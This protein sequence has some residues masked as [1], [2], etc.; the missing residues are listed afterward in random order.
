MPLYGY[1]MGTCSPLVRALVIFNTYGS[2]QTTETFFLIFPF[3]NLLN[4]STMLP[5]SGAGHEG[6]P[7]RGVPELSKSY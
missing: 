2:S 5:S 3:T 4:T 6:L 7:T 1:D